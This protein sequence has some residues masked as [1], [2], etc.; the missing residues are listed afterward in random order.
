MSDLA[1]AAFAAAT[2]VHVVEEPPESRF[3]RFCR[4]FDE[5]AYRAQL[6]ERGLRFVG[7]NEPEEVLD[8]LRQVEVVLIQERDEGRRRG[9][10][11]GVAR[12][13][14]PNRHPGGSLVPR[15]LPGATTPLA[16]CGT[17]LGIGDA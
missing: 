13:T 10:H 11:A 5:A 4:A 9:S 14:L 6:R 3:R 1:L 2:G 7:R 15:R 16:G 17:R 12:R 8:V